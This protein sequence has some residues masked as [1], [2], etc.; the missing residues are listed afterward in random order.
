M[1]RTRSV[2]ADIGALVR[3]TRQ[4][5]GFS[6]AQL[7]EMLGTTQSAVSLYEAGERGIS[8][9]MT[10]RIARALGRPVSYFLGGDS[11]FKRVDN[12]AVRNFLAE[13]EKRPEEL[14][15]LMRYWEW[16]VWKRRRGQ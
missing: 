5:A 1:A 16:L 10:M 15:S 8:I 14:Q 9:D 4:E 3:R 2:S 11:T 12:Q 6:Q 7:A 13:A